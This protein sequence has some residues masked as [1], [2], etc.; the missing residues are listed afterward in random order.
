MRRNN[1]KPGIAAGPSHAL[2]RQ[3][4]TTSNKYEDLSRLFL[5]DGFFFRLGLR[6]A[7]RPL[8]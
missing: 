5:D 1:K 2:R 7:T 4:N 8:G 6:T 3:K